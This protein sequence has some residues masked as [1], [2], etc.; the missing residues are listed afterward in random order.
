MTYV[1]RVERF[2][3]WSVKPR[4][5]TVA[6]DTLGVVL[7]ILTYTTALVI[8]VNVQRQVL[9]VHFWIIDA[10]VRV[11]ETVAGC[12]IIQYTFK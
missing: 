2:V 10:L 1:S 12:K 4:L 6:I 7:A 5:A 9:L 8:T 11:S 3:T